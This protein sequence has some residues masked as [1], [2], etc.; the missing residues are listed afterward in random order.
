MSPIASL[1]RRATAV[2]ARKRLDT[3][4]WNACSCLHFNRVYIARSRIYGTCFDK[5]CFEGSIAI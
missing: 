3:P 5:I 4:D 2:L 1:L